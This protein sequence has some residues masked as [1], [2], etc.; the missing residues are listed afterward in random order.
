M[1]AEVFLENGNRVLAVEPNADMRDQMRPSVEQHLGRPAPQLEIID[2][3]AE[4][5]TLPAASIDMVAVGRAFHW[6]DQERALAEFR[7][8]LKPDGWVALVA[9]DRD[10]DSKDPAYRPADRRLR[11]PDVHP[12]PRLHP[13]RPLR[14]SHLRQDGDASSTASSTS[15]NSPALRQLD[16]DT[17]R[18]HT[19]S[20][21]VSPQPGHPNHELSARAAHL[22]RDV[23]PRRHLHHAHHLLDHRRALSRSM[24]CGLRGASD[25]GR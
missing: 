15:R 10:R 4:A 2:A 20:L 18:G 6:F 21:S 11:T 16:W 22:L 7:R 14:L 25:C 24:N 8:I 17:F 9:A 12:W 1:V 23:R 19:M 5:T 13:R 3:T